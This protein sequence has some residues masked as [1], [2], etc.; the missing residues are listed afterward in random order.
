MITC[1][2]C[3]IKTW[4]NDKNINLWI[5]RIY[6]EK[7]NRTTLVYRDRIN[8]IAKFKQNVLDIILLS[9][10]YCHI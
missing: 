8:N 1:Y 4:I 9:L 7:I 3:M 2:L 5:Q 10:I 6:F